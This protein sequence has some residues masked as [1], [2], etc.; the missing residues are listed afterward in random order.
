[1]NL[2]IRSGAIC[3]GP[4]SQ[5]RLAK[6]L[7]TEVDVFIDPSTLHSYGLPALEAVASNVPVAS[8]NNKGILEYMDTEQGMLFDSVEPTESVARHILELLMD[9]KRRQTMT[10]LAKEA[11]VVHDRQKSVNTFIDEIEKRFSLSIV[12]RR[13]V[14]V[15]PHMRKHGGPTTLIEIANALAKHGHDVS[16]TTVYTD[17]NPEVASMTDLPINIDAQSIPKCDVLITN[18]DNPMCEALSSLRQAKKKIMLKLSHNPRFKILEEAGLNYKWDAVVTSTQWL[19]DVCEN[20]SADWDYKSVKAHRVG[21]WHYGHENMVYDQDERKWGDGSEP[22]PFVIGF[23]VHAHPSKGTPEIV[24]VLGSLF[25]E[26]GTNVKFTGVGEIPPGKFGINLPNFRYKFSPN[27]VEM[28]DIMQKCDLWVGASH[29]EGLGRMALEAMSAGCSCVLTD[30]GAEYAKHEEN[31]LLYPIGDH[32]AMM[33]GIQR[34]LKDE[35]LRKKLR[36]NGFNTAEKL[37]NPEDCIDNFEEVI[38]NLFG[39]GKSK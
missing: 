5:N 14:M 35:K 38:R 2:P 6:L 31:C 37:S 22:N 20:P 11:L 25:R 26:M 3:L 21:W 12:K 15:V 16:I 29:T 28:A 7:A 27:R 36:T 39:E 19:K 10:G 4:L 1:M 30:T 33:D 23:L 34:L 13:I 17:I 24:R 8:W 32:K 9:V 18:S